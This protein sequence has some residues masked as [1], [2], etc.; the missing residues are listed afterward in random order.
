MICFF[1]KSLTD[2]LG[3][4]KSDREKNRSV[5]EKSGVQ[6]TILEIQQYQRKW[7]QDL[8]RMDTDKN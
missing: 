8:E 4:N 5:K 3:I 1:K 7:L 2:L 6:N